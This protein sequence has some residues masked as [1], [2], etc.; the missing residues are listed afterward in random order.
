MSN[1]TVGEIEILSIVKTI[2]DFCTILLAHKLKIYIE[3]KHLINST[4]VSESPHTQ[5][6]QWIIEKFGPDLKYIN[7]PWS[8][9]ADALS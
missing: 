1:Y 2:N 5:R 7:G 3:H 4:S 8:V 6:W 9:V